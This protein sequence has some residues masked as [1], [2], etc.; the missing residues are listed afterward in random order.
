MPGITRQ[1]L[2]NIV[3]ECLVEILSEGVGHSLNESLKRKEVVHHKNSSL[4][5]QVVQAPKRM[6]TDTLKETIRIEAAGNSV[7][8]DILSDTARTTLP[9]MLEGDSARGGYIQPTGQAERHVAASTPEQL[10]GD[11]AT[12]KWASLAFMNP[13]KK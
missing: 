7:L 1:Q 6:M 4:D 12:S 8:A 9:A 10:F 2:K 3:K 5:R 13:T 11:E